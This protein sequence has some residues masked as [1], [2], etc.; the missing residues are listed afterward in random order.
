MSA[1]RNDRCSLTRTSQPPHDSHMKQGP[2]PRFQL[3]ESRQAQQRAVRAVSRFSEGKRVQCVSRDIPRLA[4]SV[5]THKWP[6]LRVGVRSKH[7]PDGQSGR[8]PPPALWL[9]LRGCLMY[10]G[11]EQAGGL[12]QRARGALHQAWT[13]RGRSRHDR[14]GGAFGESVVQYFISLALLAGSYSCLHSSSASLFMSGYSSTRSPF[15]SLQPDG[16][17]H[18]RQPIVFRRFDMGSWFAKPGITSCQPHKM[19]C[20]SNLRFTN[21]HSA[22]RMLALR[23]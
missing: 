15:L 1:A 4:V 9:F 14:A 6:A 7:A 23:L 22:S 16:K 3:S 18:I 8:E 17:S 2:P 20:T 19:F 12:G 5:Q 10:P 13:V 21:R 11:R